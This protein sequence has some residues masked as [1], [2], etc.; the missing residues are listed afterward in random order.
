MEALKR[1]SGE[2]SSAGSIE[3]V[4]WQSA[5]AAVNEEE[6]HVKTDGVQCTDLA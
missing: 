3:R 5:A 4:P 2:Q 6:A 1:L